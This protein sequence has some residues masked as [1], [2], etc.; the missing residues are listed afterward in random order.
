V[1]GGADLA[2]AV[3][4]HGLIDEYRIYVHP[5]LLGRGRPLFQPSDSTTRLHLAE[6]RAFGNGVVLLR[7]S[8]PGFDRCEFGVVLPNTSLQRCWLL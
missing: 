1:V 8:A 4:A 5:V 6:T 2:A 7:T 3:R